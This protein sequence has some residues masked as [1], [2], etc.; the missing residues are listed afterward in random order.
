M[1]H[2]LIHPV[3]LSGGS[4]TR[5]WPLS[6]SFYPK[7]FLPLAGKRTL[8]QDTATRV[9]PGERFAAP[10]VICNEEH[11]FIVA[12]QLQALS[13]KPRRLVLEPF[14]RNTAPACAVAALLVAAD[15]PQGLIAILP[16]DHVI[17]EPEA[18][19]QAMH[20]AAH[21]AADGHLVT[22]GIRPSQPETGYGYIE[23]GDALADDCFRV[24]RFIEK[25]DAER[26]QA[27]FDEALCLWNSGMFVFSAQAFLDELERRQPAVVRACRAAVAGAASETDFLRLDAEAFKG[28]PSVSIDYGVME[29]TDRAAVVPAS[30]GWNDVGSWSALWSIGDKDTEGNVTDGDVLLVDAKGSYVRSESGLVAAVGI[31]DLI[32]V[33]TDDAVLVSHRDRTQDVKQVVDRL[34][35][36]ARPE[37]DLHR[38]VYR[39]W[40]YYQSIDAG[41]LFQVKQL[42]IK[43]GAQL[44]LQMHYHRAEHW[45]VVEGTARI[46]CDDRSFLLQENESTF[47]PLGAKHRLE[48]PGKI[49][50][51]LIEVQS[52]TYLG[53][54]DIVRFEDNYGRR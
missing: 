25:P 49:P 19:H 18:F 16:S 17:A 33:A 35:A 28:C 12:E 6:R 47:I 8:L 11:R 1:T 22:F 40:G 42:M 24:R 51:R 48:N 9:A 13:I 4:G 20:V 30:F 38:R 45:I 15:D 34:K 26:A 31:E 10:L 21:A 14:G 2:T 39:P 41:T 36:K 5:L 46:T 29:H 50:L 54:D 43:P 52:G 7:Q 27:L 3:I 44:S 23:P 53:E 32:I 37:G